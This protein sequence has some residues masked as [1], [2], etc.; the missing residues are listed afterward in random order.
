[1][2]S[3][4]FL[5]L[6]VV[7]SQ[8]TTLRENEFQEWRA[9]SGRF[10]HNLDE[11]AL[12][13]KVFSENIAYIESWNRAHTGEYDTKLAMNDFGDLTNEEFKSMF[14][15]PV[16]QK[17]HFSQKKQVNL[18]DLPDTVDW[19]K[20]NAVV[21]VKDQASCGSCW[22]FSAVGTMEGAW[23]IETGNLVSLSEQ[24][25]VDCSTSYGNEGCN[26]GEMSDAIQYV[27]DAGGIMS[28][29]AYAYKGN[30]GT[31]K[32]DKSKIVASFTSEHTIKEGDE[33]ELQDSLANVG[34]VA[35]AID[36]SHLSFQFYS[37][38][39]YV[40][41]SCKT[42]NADLDHGVLAVGYG[43][44]GSSPSTNQY[45]IVKNSW[46]TSWGIKGYIWM[47]RNQKNACGIA[48]V[49]TYAIA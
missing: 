12:R 22:A 17:Q 45:Y 11:Y 14:L 40:E 2:K 32:F 46:G 26:G 31:C 21:G 43:Y 20:K 44:T 47:Q 5:A 49:A 9:K 33:A 6:L 37:S 3:I 7:F 24:Q 35:V 1:M 8:C 10:Y 34:P 25:L 4:I 27:I 16:V 13:L 18:G 42:A 39:I 48:T 15:N 30:D 28:E 23:A 41:K 36:A 38:G 29:A 19:T